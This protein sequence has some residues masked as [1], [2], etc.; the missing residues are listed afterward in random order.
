MSKLTNR[1]SEWS[2]ERQTLRQK[3][4]TLRARHE[5]TTIAS[6]QQP[7]LAS[8]DL[9]RAVELFDQIESRISVEELV[10]DLDDHTLIPQKVDATNANI[11]DEV[12]QILETESDTE[13]YGVATENEIAGT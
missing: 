11:L 6:T 8:D 4:E 13:E 9:N 3:L 5:A 7:E 12:D 2:L 1:F 10:G